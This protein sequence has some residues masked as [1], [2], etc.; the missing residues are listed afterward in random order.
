M[1]ALHPRSA[2]AIKTLPILNLRFDCER[3]QYLPLVQL[4]KFTVAVKACIAI[5][6][7]KKHYQ[8]GAKV[9]SNHV[10]ERAKRHVQIPCKSVLKVE[11]GL[12]V[13]DE[14]Q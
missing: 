6:Q 13:P 9:Y 5:A 7:V 14:S 11:G 3:D 2:V 12:P 4:A 10:M 1:G 8:H